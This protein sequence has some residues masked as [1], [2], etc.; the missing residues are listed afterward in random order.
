MTTLTPS[1]T[2]PEVR[3]FRFDFS[4]VPRYWH[5]GRRSLTLFFDNLS[6][7][8]PAAERFFMTSMK[9][10]RNQIADEQLRGELDAFC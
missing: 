3:D 2:P 8:F 4:S 6:V 1:R 10:A 7:F 9:G 5:G